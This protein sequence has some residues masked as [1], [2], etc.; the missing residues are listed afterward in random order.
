MHERHI[1]EKKQGRQR[2]MKKFNLQKALAGEPVITRDGRPVKI[3]GY[4][5]DAD[6]TSKLAGWVNSNVNSWHSNGKYWN[7]MNADN[8]LF[9][10]PTERKQ[11]VLVVKSGI[12]Y[13]AHGPYETIE[14]LEINRPYL[15]SCSDSYSIHE[16]T[17]TE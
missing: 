3:A 7:D 6:D 13:L 5:P 9:M 8:D 15:C 4:N 1:T 10:A 17:I 2:K 11:F 14:R 12:S 16:I